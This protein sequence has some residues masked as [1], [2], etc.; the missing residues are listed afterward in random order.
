MAWF[1]IVKCRCPLCTRSK[2][3]TYPANSK[4]RAKMAKIPTEKCPYAES[5]KEND[6]KPHRM[7][8]IRKRVVIDAVPDITDSSS[9]WRR[10]I[11]VR[12]NRKNEHSHIDW[13]F[14]NLLEP[15]WT[16]LNILLNILLNLLEHSWTFWNLRDCEIEFVVS[17]HRFSVKVFLAYHW[18]VHY[19]ACISS[20]CSNVNK[21]IRCL[22]LS[23]RSTFQFR[24]SD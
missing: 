20:C 16:F 4:R 5:H 17:W 1:K 15:S 22:N 10:C 3:C 7:N 18:L 6:Y 23:H 19:H 24:F 2:I 21:C 8:V 9:D 13:T 11:Y 14:L 12:I